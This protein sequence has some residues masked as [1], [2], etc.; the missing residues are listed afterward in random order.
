VRLEI[1]MYR[2]GA[3]ASH[4]QEEF[5]IIEDMHQARRGCSARLKEQGKKKIRQAS[6]IAWILR[7]DASI[8]CIDFSARSQPANQLLR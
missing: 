2:P 3:A 6:Y 7:Q 1:E 5:A 8:N 4:V